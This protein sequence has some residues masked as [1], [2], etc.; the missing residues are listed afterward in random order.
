MH[1]T[2]VNLKIQGQQK[3]QFLPENCAVLLINLQI[4][5]QVKYNHK[6]W[7]ETENKLSTVHSPNC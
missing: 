6:K 3:R 7:K 2:T 4:I 1:P 5:K